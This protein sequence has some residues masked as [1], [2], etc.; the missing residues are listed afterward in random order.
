[1]KHSKFGDNFLVELT[2]DEVRIIKSALT[3][4]MV[5][6]GG[7]IKTEDWANQDWYKCLNLQCEFFDVD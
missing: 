6:L 7:I 2:S 5:H 1:M 4:R 3:N